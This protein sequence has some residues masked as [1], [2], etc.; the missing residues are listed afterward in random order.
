MSPPDIIYPFIAY[1]IT[2]T[3]FF[4]LG[5]ERFRQSVSDK[6]ATTKDEIFHRI[7]PPTTDRAK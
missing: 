2:N 3:D 5:E 4:S 1:K 7:T 6:T